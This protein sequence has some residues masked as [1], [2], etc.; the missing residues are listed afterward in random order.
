MV[1]GPERTG[2]ERRHLNTSPSSRAAR[3]LQ[4]PVQSRSRNRKEGGGGAMLA[5][6]LGDTPNCA[7]GS[8]DPMGARD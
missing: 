8:G 7:Q 3:G 1:L 5:Y 6:D 4:G 2:R